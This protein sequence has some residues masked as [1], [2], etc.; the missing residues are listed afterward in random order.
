MNRF[1][2]YAQLVRL[3]NLPTALADIC[4]AALALAVQPPVGDLADGF[5]FDRLALLLLASAC[6]YSAGMVWN[7]YF[8]QEQD[9]RER[10]FRPLPSGRVTPREVL[11]LGSGL[12]AAG[13]VFAYFASTPSFVIALSLVVAILLYDRILKRFWMGPIGMGTC[14][15]LNVLLGL[16]LSGTIPMPWGLHLAAVVGLY[17]VGVTWLARTEARM[18]EKS[19]LQG[20]AVVM[21]LSLLLALALPVQTEVLAASPVFPYLLVLLGFLLGFPLSKAIK[22]PTPEY[23]QTAVKRCLLGLIVLDAILTTAL[24]GTV[25]LVVLLLLVPLFALRRMRWLYAT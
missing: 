17:I 11:S 12:M 25:G 9:A 18:S 19:S 21:L 23:V 1:R 22:H 10:P 14:R 2:V 4:M 20:A 15:F 13:V 7:D 3:P 24:A 6:L 16:S 8:D 5:R